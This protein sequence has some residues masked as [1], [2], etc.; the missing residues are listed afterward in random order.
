MAIDKLIVIPSDFNFIRKVSEEVLGSLQ[1]L[2]LGAYE[3][4]DIRLC[5]EEAL[6]NAIKYGNRFDKD[7]KVKVKYSVEKSI[8]KLIIEDAGK[9]FDYNSLPD[10][11]LEENLQELK[12]RGVFLIKR[13]MNEVYFN[14]KG[15][16]ITMLK[17]ITGRK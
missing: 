2:K 11:T 10:P 14:E 7:L 13:L 1:P 17:N 9:G 15:N 3:L 4:L 5:L 16:R 6:I 8:L 12:G